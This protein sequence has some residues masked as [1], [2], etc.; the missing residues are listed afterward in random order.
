MAEVTLKIE[1]MSCQHCVMSVKKAVDAVDGVT[2]SEVAVGSATI[3]FND[4]KASRDAI[5]RA[6]QKAGYTVL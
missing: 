1:G 4:E 5:V 2:S 3:V 6:V